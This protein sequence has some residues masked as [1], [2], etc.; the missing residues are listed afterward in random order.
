MSTL[1]WGGATLD[2]GPDLFWEDEFSWA[3]VE[4][5]SERTV[6]GALIISQ[7]VKTG[8][9]PI[10]LRPEDDR[11]AWIT[12]EVLDQLRAWSA[13]PG[14]EFV[15][16]LRGQARSVVFSHDGGSGVEAEPVMHFS[17]VDPSDYY[18]PKLRFI[19]V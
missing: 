5:S 16:T 7:A 15:L 9:R 18:R 13:V 10:T 12:R 8:G 14:R 11:S 4:Q 3:P 1:T 2:L 17:D 19:E 6:T